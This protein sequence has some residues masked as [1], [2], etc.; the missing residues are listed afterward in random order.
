MPNWNDKFR[1]GIKA[2]QEAQSNAYRLI[3]MGLKKHL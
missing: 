3:F 2:G 1:N